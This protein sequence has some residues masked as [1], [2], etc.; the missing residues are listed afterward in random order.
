[1]AM[2]WMLEEQEMRCTAK[3]CTVYVG[4]AA[5]KRSI[6]GIGTASRLSRISDGLDC[7]DGGD[8]K[9]DLGIGGR[10]GMMRPWTLWACPQRGR[11]ND[12]CGCALAVA[13]AAQLLSQSVAVDSGQ[14]QTFAYCPAAAQWRPSSQRLDARVPM[15]LPERRSYRSARPLVDANRGAGRRKET[16]SRGG[17]VASP[18]TG[19]HKRGPTLSQGGPLARAIPV[20]EEEWFLPLLAYPDSL[21]R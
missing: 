3:T 13:V 5:G 11:C 16:T 19:H 10:V 18:P 8:A 14:Q 2:D 12:G 17:V 6:R 20:V 7:D 9:K 4:I 1:M 21:V 15:P